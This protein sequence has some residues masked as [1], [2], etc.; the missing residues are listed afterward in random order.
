MKNEQQAF[1]EFQDW[2]VIE[3]LIFDHRI[4]KLI[5]PSYI[6]INLSMSLKIIIKH[7]PVYH[8]STIQ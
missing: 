3:L 7:L 4:S 1:W 8:V 2:A 5:I 6:V